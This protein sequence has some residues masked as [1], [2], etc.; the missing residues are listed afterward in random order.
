MNG[1][2]H[3]FTTLGGDVIETPLNLDR[4]QWE[5][6]AASPD[7]PTREDLWALADLLV[8]PENSRKLGAID[9]AR[10]GAEWSDALRGALSPGESGGSSE[11]S[12]EPTAPRSRSTSAG[13]PRSRSRK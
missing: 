10:W 6:Y 5:A 11:P 7:A 1:P 4:D 13:S 3:T 8:G 9:I 2:V 12:G